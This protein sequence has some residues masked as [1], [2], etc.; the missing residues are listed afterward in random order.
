VSNVTASCLYHFSYFCVFIFLSLSAFSSSLT[1]LPD[2]LD[3]SLAGVRSQKMIN[4]QWLLLTDI[5]LLLLRLSILSPSLSLT[6]FLTRGKRSKAGKE[7]G[8]KLTSGRFC[9]FISFF[10][11]IKTTIS[12]RRVTLAGLCLYQNSHI[13]Q[14]C[15]S[16]LPSLYLRLT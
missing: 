15:Q 16:V 10:S 6:H 2:N 12:L 8:D 11:L 4:V 5:D 13:F 3:L 9:C 1:L 7:D 14:T